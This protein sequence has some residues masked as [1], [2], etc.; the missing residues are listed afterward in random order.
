MHDL[1]REALLAR[2]QAR[3]P[4]L[5]PVLHQRVAHWYA[6]HDE[7][8]EAIAHALS[9]AD[10]AYA[11][12]LIERAANKLWLS[13]EA[14]TVLDWIG[15]LPDDILRQHARLA[16]DAALRLL[17]SLHWTVSPSYARVQAQ[18]E[19]TIARVEALLSPVE[20]TTQP[21]ANETLLALPA[22]EAAVLQRRIRL[23]QVLIATRA[24]LTRGEHERMRLLAQEIAGLTDEEVNWKMIPLSINFWLTESIQREGALLI[25]QLLEA[26][27]QMVQAGDHLATVRVMRWLSFAYRRAGQLRSVEQ[28]CLEALALLDRVGGRTA[29]AGYLHFRLAETYYAW[30]RLEAAASSLQQMLRIAH[31][32]QQVDM[33]VIGYLLLDGDFTQQRPWQRRRLS[34]DVSGR[35]DCAWAKRRQ[36]YNWRRC[37]GRVGGAG[38]ALLRRRWA[39]VN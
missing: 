16:L 31:V 32:W 35:S 7:L 18:V 13:G 15:K 33:Q 11:T 2:L 20:Q 30:N 29:M 21:E 3:E 34:G 6:T 24:I 38:L 1:F 17:E 12:A 19:Q 8:R 9:A 10:F 26:K 37:Y 36:L 14:Q 28:E 22:A 25:P 39:D 23:L 27:Q 4:E 5:V